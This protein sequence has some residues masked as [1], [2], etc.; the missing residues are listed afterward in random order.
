M[1][2]G[3]VRDVS[4]Q[5][6]EYCNRLDKAHGPSQRATRSNTI[7]QL[8][9]GPKPNLMP[10]LALAPLPH[11]FAHSRRPCRY[12]GML[13]RTVNISLAA[14]LWLTTSLAS[15]QDVRSS[16]SITYQGQLRAGTAGTAISGTVDLEFRLFD[17]ASG[18]TQIGPRLQA[19]AVNLVAGRFAAT[20]D[21][22]VP[23][24]SGPS[25]WL[26]ISVRGPGDREFNTI[27]PRQLLTR[28]KYSVMDGASDAAPVPGPQGPQGEVGPAGPPGP[29]GAPGQ[30]GPKGEPGP[31]GESGPAGPQGPKG[32]AGASPFILTSDVV[33][34]A[35]GRLIIGSS[36]E[37]ADAK[38]AV[39]ITSE[40]A[41]SL[42]ATNRAW[43]GNAIEADITAGTGRAVE[44]RTSSPDNGSAGVAGRATA[45]KGV[46]SGV[47]G[48]S[49]SS[50]GFGISAVNSAADGGI[51]LYA[52]TASPAGRAI[53]ALGSVHID[54][55]TARTAAADAL[56]IEGKD[57]RAA[58]LTSDLAWY[59]YGF[60]TVSDVH[61]KQNFRIIDADAILK[62][63]RD[64]PITEW[65]YRGDS[66]RHV[67]PMAQDFH[68]TFGVGSD[69]RSISSID[70]QG[71]AFAAIQALAQRQDELA[72]VA[73][74]RQITHLG[75]AFLGAGIALGISWAFRRR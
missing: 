61:A 38:R 52:S 35:T 25:R 64:I 50:S 9:V 68:A 17:A 23:V 49:S 72:R 71:V 15:A 39:T 56:V 57:G 62:R 7:A 6:K 22:G 20:L 46:V 40:L 70:A 65:S 63:L 43:G 67:G 75:S 45:S 32:D 10:H 42:Y 34:L 44:G 2:T 54:N 31:R 66:T 18:G 21:F 48:E 12:P 1:K 33:S 26:E 37:D 19:D 69:E 73:S 13:P 74:H 3:L 28:P 5:C 51:G 55:R 47:R 29:Q 8:P 27:T 59:A 60:N 53:S 58:A 16:T 36:G 4:V 11:S 41:T 14:C 30:T 24:L